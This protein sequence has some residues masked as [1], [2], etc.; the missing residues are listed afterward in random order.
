VE[1]KQYRREWILPGAKLLAWVSSEQQRMANASPAVRA[2]AEANR[3]RYP[4]PILQL[5]NQM[6]GIHASHAW[7][8]DYEVDLDHGYEHQEAVVKEL[9]SRRRNEAA[10]PRKYAFVY[11][12]A[13]K[14]KEEP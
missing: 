10:V 7:V 2:M 4:T 6:E 1:P 11:H 3:G 14:V 8:K 12:D 5:T 9:M 13:P